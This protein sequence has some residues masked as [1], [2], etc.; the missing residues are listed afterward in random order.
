MR[1]QVYQRLGQAAQAQ[2]DLQKATEL[3]SASNK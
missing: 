1:S 2:A 3:D